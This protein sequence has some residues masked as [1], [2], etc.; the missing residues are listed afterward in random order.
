M[1]IVSHA[2]ALSKTRSMHTNWPWRIRTYAL[3]KANPAHP[4]TNFLL[5]IFTNVWSRNQYAERKKRCKLPNNSDRNH[6]NLYTIQEPL[7]DVLLLRTTSILKIWQDTIEVAQKP[8]KH[9]T[10][11]DTNRRKGAPKNIACHLDASISVD[12]KGLN[13]NQTRNK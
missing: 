7:G 11:T 8:R 1:R 12:F 2:F 9:R 3:H 6:T 5:R 13:Q 10:T 4:M